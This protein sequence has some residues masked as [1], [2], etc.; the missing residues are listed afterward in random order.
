ME[1][2]RR[3]K[4]KGGREETVKSHPESAPESGDAATLPDKTDCRPARHTR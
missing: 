3:R 2:E 1:A 4:R